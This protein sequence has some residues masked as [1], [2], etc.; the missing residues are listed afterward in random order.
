MRS[1]GFSTGAIALGDF[2]LAL[3]LLA[4][5][6]L[7]CIELSALRISEVDVLV[8]AIPTL[9]LSKYG[10]ISLH[11]PSSYPESKESW[12]AELLYSGVP[13]E[14]PIVLH[15]DAIFDSSIWQ[16]F[17][18]RIAIE[19]MDRR[20]PK[21]RSLKELLEV[22]MLLPEASLCFDI[23]HA[24]QCDPSMTEAFLILTT[25]ASRMVHMHLSEVSTDSQ[26][27]PVSYGAKLA[28]QQVTS[29]I[30][31]K[32]P[33][34]LESRVPRTSIGDEIVDAQSAFL[35]LINSE[36]LLSV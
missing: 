1:I 33:V 19:N 31:Q 5:Y 32:T 11:A 17:G 16:R 24:Y 35:P 20:K 22:F 30:D 28:F 3:S 10:Y 29:Y 2:R 6:S 15:P 21:G 9:E 23:G 12:L 26:H 13:E 18:K 8:D 36:T 14:W 25:L 27:E 7:P 4:P 34:I